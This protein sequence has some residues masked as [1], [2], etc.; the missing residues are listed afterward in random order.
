M[1]IELPPHCRCRDFDLVRSKYKWNRIGGSE[2]NHDYQDELKLLT[3]AKVSK[4]RLLLLFLKFNLIWFNF[5]KKKLIYL[6]RMECM[7]SQ[8]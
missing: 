7:T 8:K 1:V 4:E 2:L 6:L 5:F 3:H